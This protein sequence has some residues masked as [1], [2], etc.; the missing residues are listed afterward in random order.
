MDD[1]EFNFGV[2]VMDVFKVL[3]VYFFVGVG[4]FS[5][6]SGLNVDVE[7]ILVIVDFIL[8][9]FLVGGLDK[10]VDVLKEMV[11]L[12]FLYLEVFVCFKMSLLWGVFLYGASG[13]G[14]TF[15]ARAF[16]AFCSCVGFEVVFFM[17]KGVDVL[18]KWVGEFER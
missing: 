7:I 15:I 2:G 14:K 10:Y 5:V 9:F 8:F 1:G 18:L 3:F 17:C 13:T 11:F 16:V 4:L 6:V 12:L